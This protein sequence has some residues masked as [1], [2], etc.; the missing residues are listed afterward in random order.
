MAN[1][2]GARYIGIDPIHLANGELIMN[3]EITDMIS[4]EAAMNDNNFEPVY[5]SI[6]VIPKVAKQ[7][8]PKKKSK[9]GGRR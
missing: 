4:E 7:E 8:Q 3:N 5:G 1:Y 6:K 2:K 9:K